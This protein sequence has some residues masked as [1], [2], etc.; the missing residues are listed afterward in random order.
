MHAGLSVLDFLCLPFTFPPFNLTQAS[1]VNSS[2]YTYAVES[3]KKASKMQPLRSALVTSMVKQWDEAFRVH[4]AHLM[5]NMGVPANNPE[6]LLFSEAL[7]GYLKDVIAAVRAQTGPDTDTDRTATD[8]KDTEA[9]STDAP[10][11][12]E[13]D[14][15]LQDMPNK[16]L[17][18][19]RSPLLYSV[20][21][22]ME[23]PLPLLTPLFIKAV[24]AELQRHE[25]AWNTV[26][27]RTLIPLA[28]TRF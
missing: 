16:L 1:N 8:E 2:L 5:C 13:E 15:V 6:A 20:M 11:L 12:T 9:A 3:Y 23:H 19:Y 28:T 17:W 26:S 14:L 24:T 27:L 4:Y 25:N 22:L 10:P 7:E 21:D 18:A